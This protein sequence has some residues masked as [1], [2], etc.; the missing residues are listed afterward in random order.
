MHIHWEGELTARDCKRHIPIRFE[1][2]AHTAQIE[3]AFQFTPEKVFDFGNMICLTIFDPDGF[4]GA[5]HR[6]GARHEVT[7]DAH[8]ATPGYI[9]GPL[10]AGEWIVQLD[11]HMIMPGAPLHYAL[12][13]TLHDQIA[14]VMP[15]ATRANPPRA[16]LPVR[17]PGWYRGDL[18]SHTNH[19]DADDRS[20]AQLVQ[21]AHDYGLD[22]IFLT[23][24]NTTSGLAEVGALAGPDL[25]TAG[26]LELTTFWGHALCLGARTWV[27]WRLRPSS[28]DMPAIAAA[29]YAAGQLF[30]IA[31]P[32]SIGDP[33]CTGCAWRFG[34]MMP[35]N[36]QIVEIWN[37]PWGGDSNNDATLALYYDWLNQGWHLVATAGSDTHGTQD[38]A[39]HP[40]FSVIYTEELTEAALFKAIAAGHLYLSSGPQLSLTAQTADGTRAMMGDTLYAAA[41]LT[42]NWSAAPPDAQVRLIVNGRLQE[43]WPAMEQGEAARHLTPD[44]ADWVLVEIRSAGG[45]VLAI[46][47]PIFLQKPDARAD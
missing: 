3:I 26:G 20:V 19:S 14:A 36:S 37:G 42:L 22:F 24:H 44:E 40:G 46:T 11:T 27:D 8:R 23:D 16:N 12:D 38:Y 21:T 25:Y 4:R 15:P 29:T 13:V 5:G 18:H 47:N 30:I 39:A 9:P 1:V 2:P 35:G 31:H 17:G 32:Q 34:E 28:G 6:G 43:Q 41:T 10:L 33:V 45:E 7:I